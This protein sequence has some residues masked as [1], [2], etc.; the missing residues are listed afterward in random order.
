MEQC[1]KIED[2]NRD[3]QAGLDLLGKLLQESDVNI[4]KTDT[5]IEVVSYDLG[6]RF[7]LSTSNVTITNVL[8]G[9]RSGVNMRITDIKTDGVA[10]SGGMSDS[11][12]TAKMES[13]LHKYESNT[14]VMHGQDAYSKLSST[15]GYEL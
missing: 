11:E 10:Y 15:L 8:C 2:M 12:I 7:V 14:R 5:K 9:H 6:F 13:L 3:E 1:Y 4:Y